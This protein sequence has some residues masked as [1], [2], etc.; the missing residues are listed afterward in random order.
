LDFCSN[1]KI[2]WVWITILS[3]HN[4]ILKQP[5]FHSNLPYWYD[6]LIT[7]WEVIINKVICKI[8]KF[9]QYSIIQDCNILQMKLQK[10][11]F[12]I[13]EIWWIYAIFYFFL[14]I[15]QNLDFP[16]VKFSNDE[17]FRRWNFLSVKWNS[18]KCT[19]TKL[20]HD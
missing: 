2:N 9:Q 4:L 14:I 1:E 11:G 18:V 16:S 20:M 10:K 12:K 17:I 3:R 8:L 7:I 19:Q 13:E 5:T 15:M 6:K